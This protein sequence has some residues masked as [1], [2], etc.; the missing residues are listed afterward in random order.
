MSYLNL[1]DVSYIAGL[2]IDCWVMPGAI[3]QDPQVLTVYGAWSLA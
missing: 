1:D 3:R 2:G